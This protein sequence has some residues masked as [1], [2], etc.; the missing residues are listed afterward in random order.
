MIHLMICIIDSEMSCSVMFQCSSECGRGYHTRT[1]YCSAEDGS[2][3]PEQ[4]CGQKPRT[5]KSCKKKRPCGGFWFEGPWSSVGVF[6][7]RNILSLTL[8]NSLGLQG[9]VSRSLNQKQRRQLT[10][11][12]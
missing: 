10:T 5:R 12:L 11:F 4:K 8:L 6:Y 3:L 1:V 2:P 7:V 9:F